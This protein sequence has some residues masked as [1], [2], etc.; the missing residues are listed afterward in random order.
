MAD[1]TCKSCIHYHP[2]PRPHV[3]GAVDL[4]APSEGECRGAPPL[5]Q[6]MAYDANQGR[7]VLSAPFWRKL[8]EDWPACGMHTT[9][10]GPSPLAKYYGKLPPAEPAD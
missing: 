5:Q 7:A 2:S 8:H 1:L 4:S 6:L 3:N 10:F 9:R